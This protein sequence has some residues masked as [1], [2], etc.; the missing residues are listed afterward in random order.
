MVQ[1]FSGKEDTF[2]NK[3]LI[4]CFPVLNI[5]LLGVP[6]VGARVGRCDNFFD[7]SFNAV[8]FSLIFFNINVYYCPGT[9]Q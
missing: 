7:I 9:T 5:D 2:V 6:A 8:F 4:S 3:G 1:N